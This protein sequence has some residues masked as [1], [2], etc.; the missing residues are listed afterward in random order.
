MMTSPSRTREQAVVIGP[1]FTWDAGDGCV[2]ACG[3][4]DDREFVRDLLATVGGTADLALADPPYRLSSDTRIQVKCRKDL[5]LNESWDRMDAKEFSQFLRRSVAVCADAVPR[6]SAYIWTSDW[7]LSDV[8]RLLNLH[9]FV[10]RT[11]FCWC[12]TNPAPSFR[13]NC[14]VSACEYLAIGMRPGAYFALDRMPR[15]RSYAVAEPG[16]AH[17]QWVERGIVH[18]SERIKRADGSDYLNRGQKP[19]DLTTALI[20]TACPPGGLVLDLYGG[21]GTGLAAASRAGRR[22]LY[23]ES[24]PVQFRAAAKRLLAVRAERGVDG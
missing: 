2:L 13:K 20:E 22:C 9:Q 6:G 24:D 4:A 10:V 16:D 3:P 18:H 5:F 1:G 15:Q 17:G 7:W 8:K 21:T 14:F 12:K 23:I 11:S 19:L